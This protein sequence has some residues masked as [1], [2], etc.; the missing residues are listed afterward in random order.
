MKIPFKEFSKNFKNCGWVAT[1]TRFH[2]LVNLVMLV[3]SE[4]FFPY[5]L[6]GL[7]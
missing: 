7:V 3:M 6:E 2:S 4:N 5:G 1:A